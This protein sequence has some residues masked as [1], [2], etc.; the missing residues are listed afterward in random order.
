MDEPPTLSAELLARV[1]ADPPPELWPARGQLTAEDRALYYVLARDV[2]E[3]WGEIVDAGA[4]IGASARLFAAGLCDNPR[5]ADKRGRIQVFDLFEDR[6]DGPCAT[7][8]RRLLGEVVAQPPS[9]PR[10]LR[11][12]FRAVGTR[13]VRLLGGGRF[14]FLP[15]FEQETRACREYLRVF[16]GDIRAQRPHGDRPVEI[17]SIDVAKSPELMMAVARNFFPS[18]VPG[19]SRV[20][21]QDYLFAFQPWLHV[22][23]ELL[24]DWFEKEFDTEFCSTVFRLVRPIDAAVVE[25]VVGRTRADWDRLENA[26]LIERAIARSDRR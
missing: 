10:A 2:Y 20:V 16:K 9:P 14:D 26:R 1:L 7:Q 25:R 12:V 23:M 5:V 18:L 15:V 17:L 24:A 4:L 13:V 21:H 11:R 22:F 8:I 3:G 6:V 19:R